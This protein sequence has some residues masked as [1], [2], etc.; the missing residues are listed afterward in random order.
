M[1]L[2]FLVCHRTFSW[3]CINKHPCHRPFSA[4]CCTYEYF[5]IYPSLHDVASSDLIDPSLH[6]AAF[7]LPYILLC[8]TFTYLLPAIDPFLH[9]VASSYLPQNLLCTTF[10]Y[11]TY[12]PAI[13]PSLHDVASSY[14]PQ[15]L[16]C[17]LC[18]TF[19]Y[20]LTC[21]RPFSAWRCIILPATDSS[22]HNVHLLTYLP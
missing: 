6:D 4:W 7:T 14:L 20:L 9:G 11:S 21:H 17:T 8:T 19:T 1:I 10:T 15:N 2:F 5:A 18:T 12:L 22:L 16:L 13:D 3:L